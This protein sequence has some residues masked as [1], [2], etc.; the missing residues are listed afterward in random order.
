M[1]NE[2]FEKQIELDTKLDIIRRKYHEIIKAVIG[3]KT[4]MQVFQAKY[5]DFICEYD[6]NDLQD[7]ITKLEEVTKIF[8]D[9]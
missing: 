3:C 9:L 1:Y 5:E 6:C 2:R 8:L 4:T 7:K